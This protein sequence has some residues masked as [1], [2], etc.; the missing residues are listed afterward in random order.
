MGIPKRQWF[1]G[2]KQQTFN[3][4]NDLLVITSLHH[5][6]EAGDHIGGIPENQQTHSTNTF[7]RYVNVPGSERKYVDCRQRHAGTT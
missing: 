1:Q 2:G 3:D 5:I 4:S 6:P 7:I